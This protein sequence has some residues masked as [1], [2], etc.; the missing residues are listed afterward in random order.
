MLQLAVI[1]GASDSAS[2][3]AKSKQTMPI[4][5]YIAMGVSAFEKQNSFEKTTVFPE[6]FLL[7]SHQKKTAER[8]SKVVVF[9]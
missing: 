5:G 2:Y 9:V 6:R 3:L 1:G 4:R 8:S 7:S